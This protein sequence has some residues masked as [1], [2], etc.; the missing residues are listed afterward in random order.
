MKS[1]KFMLSIIFFLKLTVQGINY[2]RINEGASTSRD[3]N[4]LSDEEKREI[5]AYAIQFVRLFV[6]D[7]VFCSDEYDEYLSMITN[8]QLN[9]Y[10]GST[11][12]LDLTKNVP[13]STILECAVY[14]DF[15]SK[16]YYILKYGQEDLTNRKISRLINYKARSLYYGKVKSKFL[17]A[18]GKN[19]RCT[20]FLDS[21]VLESSNAFSN[22]AVDLSATTTKP[23][24]KSI[25]KRLYEKCKR[26]FIK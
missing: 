17:K 11:K 18:L 26:K 21:F 4:Q 25:F 2:G 5:E 13:K 16:M 8:E 3:K 24:K 7:H 14:K 20:G 23:M 1:A 15:E 22:T 10:F 6:S 12:F 9:Y 19:P